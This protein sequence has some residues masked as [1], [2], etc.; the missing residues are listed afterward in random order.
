[1]KKKK[2]RAYLIIFIQ[3]FFVES[4]LKSQ[5]EH[6]FNSYIPLDFQINPAKIENNKNCI[7]LFHKSQW[8]RSFSDIIKFYSVSGHFKLIDNFFI[9]GSINRNSFSNSFSN[10]IFQLSSAYK[11][12]FSQ[13][14]H[15]ISL[16]IG[17]KFYNSNYLTKKLVLFDINDPQFL[18]SNLNYQNNRFDFSSGLFY[19]NNSFKISIANT[20]LLSYLNKSVNQFNDFIFELGFLFKATE[21]S[22]NYYDEL[23]Q[24]NFRIIKSEINYRRIGLEIFYDYYASTNYALGIGYRQN[25]KEKLKISNTEFNSIFFRV[26]FKIGKKEKFTFGLGHD[27]N[28]GMETGTLPSSMEGLVGFEKE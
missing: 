8:I 27:I 5:I 16:G 15:Y 1:M 6:K 12:N 28:I 22:N 13:D 23:S 7:Y 24:I 11:G 10:N 19:R 17:A 14:N 2:Y 4:N 20:N 21:K 3:F 26:L 18:N 9:G 25:F